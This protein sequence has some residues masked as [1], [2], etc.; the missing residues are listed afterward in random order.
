[1]PAAQSAV[2]ALALLVGLAHSQLCTE[3]FGE[4]GVANENFGAFGACVPTPFFYCDDSTAVNFN[5]LGK[6]HYEQGRV[7][8]CAMRIL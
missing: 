3:Q 7:A 6:R 4:N 8:E 5:A 2:G 1:M